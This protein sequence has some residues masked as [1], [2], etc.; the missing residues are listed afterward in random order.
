LYDITTSGRLEVKDTNQ[1]NVG[2]R[3]RAIRESRHL[4]LRALAERCG[5]SAN[6]IS[7]IERGENSPTVSSLH[8]LA[9]ALG[10]SIAD[11]FR[12]DDKLSAVH[13]P[14]EQRLIYRRAELVMESLGIGL[15]DQQLEPFLITVAP[16]VTSDRPI[17]HPGEEFVYC[18]EGDADYDVDGQRYALRAGDSLLLDATR[19]HSFRNPTDRSAT[20]LVVFQGSDNLSIARERHLQQE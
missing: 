11:F 3:I 1:P 13:V 20:L 5:L 10:A 18:L 17:V 15:R 4:S 19:P 12:Q 8:Q 9:G 16:G 6:A 14:R 2:A 7:L